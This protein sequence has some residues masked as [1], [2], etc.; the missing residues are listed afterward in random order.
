M[1]KDYSFSIYLVLKALILFIGYLAGCDE[2]FL[3]VALLS[4]L[5]APIFFF[6]EGEINRGK[7]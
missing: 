6:L 4:M 7:K 3:H 2:V 1:K 5:A